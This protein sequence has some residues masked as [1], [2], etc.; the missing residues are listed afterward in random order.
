MLGSQKN[1]ALTLTRVERA[2]LVEREVSLLPLTEQA[3]LLTLSRRSRYYQAL[4]PSA[5][6]VQ[7][8]HAI[9]RIYTAQPSYGSRRIAVLLARD[10]QL[11][12]HR[13][14]V[15][16]H[17]RAMG[18]RGLSPGPTLRRRNPEH[19]VYPYRLRNVAL[20][21]SNQ[22]WAIDITYIPVVGSWRYLVAVLD[23]S[24][25]SIVS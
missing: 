15:Q 5:E 14:A 1:L 7:T 12:V 23:I 16:R 21:H 17:M 8:K 24:T 6:E 18:I 11:A 9:D 4:P 2:A 25:R 13:K 10:Y 22:A 19:R 3:E 20:T